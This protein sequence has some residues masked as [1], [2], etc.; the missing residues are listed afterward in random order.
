MHTVRADAL[1]EPALRP[2]RLGTL[3][4]EGWLERQLT[5][6]AAGLSGNLD[7]LWPDV[8]S[9]QWFGGGAEAWERAPY[10]LDGAIPLAFL[11]PDSPFR[12]RVRARVEFVLE[13][14][15]ED[16]WLG[17]YDMVAYAGAAA[18]PMYDIWA[19]FLALKALVQY[20]DATGDE[21]AVTAVERNLGCIAKRI[22][23][24]P[25]HSWGQF[26]WF[27][28]LIALQWLYE[29]SGE[30]WLLELAETLAGQGF[31][32]SGFLERWPFA[33][34][35][36]KGRW[37]FASH[38]VNNAMAVKAHGLYWR[39]TARARDRAFAYD[40]IERLERCH[41]MVTGMFSGDECLAGRSPTRGTELCAVLEYQYSL[42]VLVGLFGDP[43]FADRLERVAY[44][45]MPATFSPDMWSHQYDQ[46]VNQIECSVREGRSWGTNGPASNI[47]GLEPGYGCC[48]ANLSQ[49][50]P[51]L[52]AH[53]WMRVPD[54]GSGPE[55]LAAVV[56]APCRLETSIG[57]A[58]LSVRTETEYPF[59]DSI[60]V[61]VNAEKPVRFPLL[62]RIP[63][64][65]EGAEVRVGASREPVVARAGAFCRVEREWRGGTE[66][67]LR[68]PMRPRLR[69]GFRGAVAV[70][71]GP[72]VYSLRIGEQWKRIDADAAHRELPHG[73]W[74]IYPTTSWNYALDVSPETVEAD[75]SFEERPVG[76]LPFSPDGA[77]VLARVRGRRVPGWGAV[78]GS[79]ADVPEGPV[80]STEAAETLTLI[81]YGCTN[82]RMTEM[83]L[84]ARPATVAP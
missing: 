2:L 74:E 25:L 15:H 81:P 17:P 22:D 62:L 70:E 84:L 16:G 23:R 32:Y 3:V 61:L 7:L 37:T 39:H 69:A 10:W 54:T 13:H 12:A 42:E 9:S 48:T 71:R 5:T 79:A 44:N 31:D 24:Q 76:E 72:L 34:P 35:P 60:R 14:Q 63:A 43:A 78:N 51:K 29:R 75:T 27:E 11:L 6:Q 83:P 50:W 67:S 8:A 40:M 41:G 66:L 77:P 49:G 33:E 65:A 4:P 20:H 80:A 1:L 45:A 19:Q 64:W 58:A 55:G 21:R 26:R 57:G 68:L 82:L 56:W 47:F 53:L 36:T 38:V 59:R 73:D 46:Q 52:A 30:K 18:N 28:A